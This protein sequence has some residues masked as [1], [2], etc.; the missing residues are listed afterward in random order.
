MQALPLLR[1]IIEH[2]FFPNAMSRRFSAE[3]RQDARL[4]IDPVRPAQRHRTPMAIGATGHLSPRAPCS[5]TALSVAVNL[6]LI[7]HWRGTT[8]RLQRL[9]GDDMN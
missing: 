8:L 4:G 3:E 9:N 1:L 2:S 7:G 6:S 5:L